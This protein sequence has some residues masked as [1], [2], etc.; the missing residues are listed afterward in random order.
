MCCPGSE[1]KS[2]RISEKSETEEIPG[3]VQLATYRREEEK[4]GDGGGPAKQK[5]RFD[6]SALLRPRTFVFLIAGTILLL[7]Y[8]NNLLTINALSREN[9]IM[10]ESLGV[11]R[12]VN[13]ALELELHER[14]LIHNIARSAGEMGLKPSMKP[15]IT[16]S[17]K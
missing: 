3:G 5:K 1:W 12:S 13:A 10:R 17:K 16:I 15:A 14:Y 6:F 9:E 4:A 7:I 2:A 8:I 11:S